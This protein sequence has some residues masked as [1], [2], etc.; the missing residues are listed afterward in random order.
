[1]INDCTGKTIQCRDG[2]PILCL[3]IFYYAFYIA[4]NN[5]VAVGEGKLNLILEKQITYT[6]QFL[7]I[8][9]I[10]KFY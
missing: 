5:T 9:S 3:M 1:M 4:I 7:R 6:I 8:C 2:Q 10:S